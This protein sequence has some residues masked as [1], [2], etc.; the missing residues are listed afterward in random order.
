MSQRH[1]HDT[2]ER[3]WPG[4]ADPNHPKYVPVELRDLVGAIDPATERKLR[5]EMRDL[6]DVLVEDPRTGKVLRVL[7]PAKD[8]DDLDI[9]VVMR[10]NQWAR[11]QLA[12]ERAAAE[13][14]THDARTYTCQCCTEVVPISAINRTRHTQRRTLTD[15][16]TIVVCGKCAAVAEQLA[17][18]RLAAD[19]INGQS[20]RDRAQ[21]LIDAA[22]S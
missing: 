6:T 1:E 10:K 19:T 17:I 13:Q 3:L 4:A 16:T 20:R 11:T 8:D 14:A 7:Q 9:A 22:S 5:R 2:I 15:G 21:A 12:A 18:Q